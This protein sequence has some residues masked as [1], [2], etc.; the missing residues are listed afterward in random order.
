LAMSIFLIYVILNVKSAL[1]PM[2]R[3]TH[4]YMPTDLSTT[5]YAKDDGFHI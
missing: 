1:S 2:T 4:I 3:P 5:K